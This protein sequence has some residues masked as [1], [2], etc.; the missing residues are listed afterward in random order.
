VKD[1][2]ENPQKHFELEGHCKFTMKEASV[3]LKD[4]LHLCD[5]PMTKAKLL[6]EKA[7]K[8]RATHLI[9][10]SCHRPVQEDIVNKRK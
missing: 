10:A 3:T 1:I 8:Y 7:T 4:M 6:L 2:V 9:R 5:T